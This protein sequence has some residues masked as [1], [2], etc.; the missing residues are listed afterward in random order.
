ERHGGSPPIADEM[1]T[2]GQN[3]PGMTLKATPL[4]SLSGGGG[5]AAIEVRIQGDDQKVLASLAKQV[6]DIV[7]NVPGTVDVSDGGVVGQPEMVVSINRD[8]ATDLG[9]TA[10]QIASVLR[11]GLAGS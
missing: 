9:L 3:V 5:G 2:F 4:S 6:A 8:R 7:R 11:T 10:G 1:P